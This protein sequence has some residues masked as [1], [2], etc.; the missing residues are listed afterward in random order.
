[1]SHPERDSS[2]DH[3]PRPHP[4]S[5]TLLPR[6]KRAILSTAL[7]LGTENP[8]FSRKVERRMD[9]A[10]GHEFFLPRGPLLD[11]SARIKLTASR[12]PR[13]RRDGEEDLTVFKK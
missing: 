3:V 7:L 4:T 11:I 10:M 2:A 9:S 6:Q 1:M 12:S 8:H 13:E 5:R